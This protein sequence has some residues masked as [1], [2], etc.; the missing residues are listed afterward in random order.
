M[1][2]KGIGVEEES[3]S[4]AIASCLLKLLPACLAGRSIQQFQVSS[5]K[6]RAHRAVLA[7]R[8]PVFKALLFG[9]MKDAETACIKLHNIKPAT[10]KVMLRFMYTDSLPRDEEI[11]SSSI[12][13]LFQNLLAAADMYHLDRLK[14][15]CAQKLWEHLSAETVATVLGCAEKHNCAELKN[16]CLDFFVVE[17]NF[18]NAV[19]TQDYSQLMQSFPCVID[20]IR[21]RL[22]K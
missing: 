21:A 11:K 3:P 20:E 8:S 19:L 17:K 12:I 6:F 4:L 2:F 10:F 22:Q 16:S 18:K 14:L 1:I 9:P 15:L 13:D 7:A 5:K